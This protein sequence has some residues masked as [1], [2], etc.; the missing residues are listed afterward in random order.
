MSLDLYLRETPCETCGHQREDF[1]INYTYNASHMWYEIYPDDD[2][3]VHIEGMTGEE[4]LNKLEYAYQYMKKNR[5]ALIKLEPPNGWGSYNGFL[6]F[7]EDCIA[8]CKEHPKLVWEAW[9]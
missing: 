9:R 1:N 6:G 4:A 2:G 7:I 3:M 5:E 8:A